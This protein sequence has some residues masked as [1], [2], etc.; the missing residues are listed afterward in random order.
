MALIIIVG[1]CESEAL[2]ITI[3]YIPS[4]QLST[5]TTGQGNFTN[6]FRAACDVWELA[7]QDDFTVALDVG[8]DSGGSRH[9][10]LM[11]GGTPN[12][13][14]RGR[15]MFDNQYPVPYYMDSTPYS[16]SEYTNAVHIVTED[17]GSGHVNTTRWFESGTPD[18]DMFTLAMHEIGHSL[19][20]SMAN[21]GLKPMLTGGTV[22][23][24]WPL[25]Y[26]GTSIP[27]SLNYSGFYSHLI[28]TNGG[29]PVMGGFNSGDRVLPSAI[30][31]LALAE[32][33]QFRNL[34]LELA[35]KLQIV[36]PY[37]ITR[38]TMVTNTT[39][40]GSNEITT[41]VTNTVVLATVTKLSWIQPYGT[42]SLEQCQNL[43]T[44][45]RTPV[46]GVTNLPSG[47]MN[48]PTGRYSVDLPYQT[49]GNLFYRLVRVGQ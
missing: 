43:R 4:Q 47:P 35:P 32:I 23:I 21:N 25:P 29:R 39:G 38:T 34:N 9:E 10:L 15:I 1:V 13:E 45:I 18:R 41:I 27:L 46:S 31:I 5:N 48:I 44:G 8:W 36:A 3:N 2:T 11:Q 30:D 6:I 12:R 28:T 24:T 49:T 19:G 16:L 17:L 42:Y 37:D 22:D 26:A 7:I 40:H 33:S 14:T 20:L